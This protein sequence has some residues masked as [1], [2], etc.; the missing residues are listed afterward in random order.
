VP[1]VLKSGSLNLLKPS[2]PAKAC[3]GIALPF[4]SLIHKYEATQNVL[5]PHLE[6]IYPKYFKY[7]F[8]FVVTPSYVCVIC[9]QTYVPVNR[10]SKDKK[11]SSFTSFT[12]KYSH[13]N[14][15]ALL[16]TGV[17]NRGATL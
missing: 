16:T 4:Y 8:L 14:I 9:T 6:S 15:L 13:H 7:A 12:Q 17:Y 5:R 11:A 3:N 10:D 2:G 1:I